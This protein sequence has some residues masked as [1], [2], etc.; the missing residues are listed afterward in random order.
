MAGRSRCSATSRLSASNVSR[1]P[2][3][4]AWMRA[5][6]FPVHALYA[7][8]RHLLPKVRTLLDHLSEVLERRRPRVG[9][10]PAAG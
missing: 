8:N 4:I 3:L 7:P 5:P 10:R 1:L 2:T 6:P 9:R